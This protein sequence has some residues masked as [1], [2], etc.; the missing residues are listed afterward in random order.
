MSIVKEG[1]SKVMATAFIP[2]GIFFDIPF[3]SFRLFKFLGFAAG[4]TNTLKSFLPVING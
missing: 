4:V 3:L 2:V 1:L